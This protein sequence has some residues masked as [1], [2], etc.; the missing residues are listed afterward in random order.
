MLSRYVVLLV[1]FV[2]ILL[3]GCDRVTPDMLVA[4][5]E[6]AYLN[7]DYRKAVIDLK[8]ALSEDGNNARAR[9]LLGE[10]YL[11]IGDG[12]SAEK[13]FR[14]AGTLGV[15]ADSVT[16]ALMRA[17]LL[18]EKYD[19][20]IDTEIAPG[21]SPKA[22]AEIAAQRTLAYLGKNQLDDAKKAYATALANAPELAEVRFAHAKI[23][24]AE[25]KFD[26]AKT[27]VEE[28]NKQS[29]D[30]VP[31]WVLLGDLLGRAHK[32]PE[33]EAAYTKAL[34][35]QVNPRN[36]LVKRAFTRVAQKKFD[37]AAKDA[38]ILVKTASKY[39]PGHYLSGLVAFQ[40]GKL[41]VASEHL[42]R[43]VELSPNH[44]QSVFVLSVVET[45]LDQ[46]NQAQRHLEQV[47]HMQPGF[48]PARKLLA[49]WYLR[50]KKARE[51]D[52][53]VR[54]IVAARPNDLEA[55]NLLASALVLRGRSEEA[56]QLLLQ[57]AQSEEQSSMAQLRAGIGMLSAGDAQAGLSLMEKAAELAPEDETTTTALITA[58]IE[59]KT[60]DQA[61]AIAERYLSQRPNDPAAMNLMAVT[62]FATGS[63]DKAIARYKSV[64]EKD[65]TNLKASQMLATIA[66]Q[67]GDTT[68]AAN[69]AR[70]GLEAHSG[71]MELLLIEAQIAAKNSQLE[72]A[73][74]LLTQAVDAN[75]TEMLPRANLANLLAQ[76]GEYDKALDLL[77][78]FGS[79]ADPA[80]LRMRGRIYYRLQRLDDAAR[81]LEA[82][83][84]KAPDDVDAYRMLAVVY[85]AQKNHTGLRRALDNM[86]RLSPD[87]DRALLA[88]ARLLVLNGDTLG[89]EHL[90]NSRKDFDESSPLALAT[91]YAIARQAK[92]A[93]GEVRYAEKMFSQHPITYHAVLL[94]RSYMRAGNVDT[95][96][97]TLSSW[98]KDR[99]KDIEA[100]VELA[101]LLMQN[102]ETQQAVSEMR[103][104][105]DMDPSN[106]FALNNLVWI[107]TDQSPTEA[108]R[109][110]K[111]AYELVPQSAPVMDTLALAYVQNDDRDNA[112][113]M[114][115]R[116]V[117]SA[118]DDPTYRLHRAQIRFQYGDIAGARADVNEVLRRRQLATSLKTEADTLL[119]QIEKASN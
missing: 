18:Q 74:A 7:K 72:K 55:K 26:E 94:S 113:R 70:Q 115:A 69:Y 119:Q 65:P 34:E 54:P 4:R 48:A 79:D 3:A 105:L 10:V 78:D 49:Y 35:N 53:L 90:L 51:V 103:T 104:L 31:A 15:G 46:A 89:A 82:L 59:Q 47:V 100:R 12:P 98:L 118:P 95:A 60:G 6:T 17:Q 67:D 41:E 40:Q 66:M 68:S 80:L 21:M 102:S 28:I 2:G 93:E 44:L 64:L 87:D 84:A 33:A 11:V 101:N 116:A 5:A 32:F 14:H 114:I 97:Q 30:Y 77:S 91:R 88:K 81:D 73:E 13:E 107:L 63:K 110:A 25:E 36:E 62:Q 111:K 96:K 109:Y 56:A 117:D 71:N 29:T 16:P 58:Y 85:D 52:G 75:P 45:R 22:T 57:V 108:L 1:V 23:L 99:P 37:E 50:D 38:E 61:L 43:A 106:L 20:V 27:V 92:D 9:W 86:L 8:A 19:E 39:Q 83:V 42:E 112:L 76:R 24:A